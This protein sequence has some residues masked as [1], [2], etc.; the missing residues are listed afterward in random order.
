MSNIF[1][2]VGDFVTEFFKICRRKESTDEILGRST[3][4]E[5]GRGDTFLLF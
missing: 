5:E 4:E 3:F 2:Y 1:F